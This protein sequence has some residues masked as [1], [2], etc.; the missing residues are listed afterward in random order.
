MLI[1]CMHNMVLLNVRK[2]YMF[3]ALWYVL[4]IK[5]LH[6]IAFSLKSELWMDALKIGVMSRNNLL[7]ARVKNPI[8]QT[9]KLQ[10][11]YTTLQVKL[12]TSFFLDET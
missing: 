10:K 8:K 3:P 2:S 9:L 6:L 7:Y 12:S 4:S 11:L 5:L 1:K